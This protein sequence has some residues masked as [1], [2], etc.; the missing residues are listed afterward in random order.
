MPLE[1]LL[2]REGVVDRTEHIAAAGSQARIYRFA[3]GGETIH[4]GGGCRGGAGFEEIIRSHSGGSQ[5]QVVI[6]GPGN[7]RPGSRQLLTRK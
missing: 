2:R 3:I 1:W 4:H 6:G 5:P 7:R